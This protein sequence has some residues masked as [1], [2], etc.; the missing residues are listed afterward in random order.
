MTGPP[1]CAQCGHELGV[2]RYCTNCGLPVEGEWRTDTAERPSVPPTVAAGGVPPPAFEPPPRARYPLFADEAPADE[3]LADAG[4]PA[5][6]PVGQAPPTVVVPTY[7]PPPPPGPSGPPPQTPPTS[8]RRRRGALPWMV[9]LTAV[10]LLALVGALLLFGGDD[11]DD[12]ARDP[13]SSSSRTQDSSAPTSTAPPSSDP[14]T[15]PPTTPPPSGGPPQDLTGSAAVLAPATAPPGTDVNGDRVTYRADNMLDGVPATAWRMPGNG[16]GREIRID[17]GEPVQLE[18]VG[19]VNG[20]AKRDP[21]YDGYTANRRITRVVWRFDDGSEQAQ[22]LDEV[23]RMQVLDVGPVTTTT[24][25]MRIVTV[26]APGRGRQGRDYTAISDLT[27]MG[28]AAG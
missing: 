5:G 12:T 26:T 8:H 27:L 18:Q 17:F 13:A 28:T 20:Y 1:R 15:P 10:V 25:T 4:T 24:V 22:L 3:A 6:G 23:R 19:I 11:A 21:G 16:T 7:E 2:G 14:T 9:A